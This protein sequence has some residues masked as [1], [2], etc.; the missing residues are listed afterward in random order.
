[1]LVTGA[2]AL[3]HTKKTLRDCKTMIGSRQRT[4]RY[5]TTPHIK[6][7]EKLESMLGAQEARPLPLLDAL[8]LH[9]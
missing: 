9:P 3:R 8:A 6:Q 7:L 2:D 4:A 1:M 5:I